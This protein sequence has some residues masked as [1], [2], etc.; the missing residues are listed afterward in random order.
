[1]NQATKREFTE[2]NVPSDKDRESTTK[3]QL[4]KNMLDTFRKKKQ[5][6]LGSNFKSSQGRTP[7]ETEIL[8]FT[9]SN[10]SHEVLIKNCIGYSQTIQH[11][12]KEILLLSIDTVSNGT[13]QLRIPT[14][15]MDGMDQHKSQ[16]FMDQP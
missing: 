2:K 13:W 5:W 12:F 3:K 6:L 14:M 7:V 4:S 15:G 10:Q 1:M 9:N 11:E 16:R 8:S